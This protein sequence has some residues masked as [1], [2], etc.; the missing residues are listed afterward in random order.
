MPLRN[1]STPRVKVEIVVDLLHRILIGKAIEEF[2]RTDPRL[3]R[4][5]RRNRGR[6]F[7]RVFR[8]GLALCPC[9]HRSRYAKQCKRGRPK[10]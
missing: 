7:G 1:A 6:Y 8:C 2:Q 9:G 5:R 10:S 4:V 3:N